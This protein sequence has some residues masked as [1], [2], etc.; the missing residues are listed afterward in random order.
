MAWL[1]AVAELQEGGGEQKGNDD[2]EKTTAVSINESLLLL[3]QRGID[4]IAPVAHSV[5]PSAVQ[6]TCKCQW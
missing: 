6:S 1:R 5:S 4:E 2:R 3:R